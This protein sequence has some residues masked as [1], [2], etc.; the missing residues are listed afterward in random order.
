[1]TT[2]TSFFTNES[3]L[4]LKDRFNT[5]VKGTALF[6]CLVGYFYSSGFYLIYPALEH[7]DNIRILI[8]ISTS[9][10]TFRIIEEGNKVG[11]TDIKFSHSETKQTIEDAVKLEMETSDD[12]HH[13]EEGVHKFIEW[14]RSGKLIIKAYPSQKIHAKLYI[15]TFKDGS[16]DK[17][18]VITGSS[19]FT[20][21]GLEDN[22]EFNVELK[23]PGDYEFAKEKFDELWEDAVDVSE[24]YVETIEDKS[25]FS[26]KVTPYNLYLK[27]LY[28]YFKTDLNETG[29][30]NLDH[31]PEEFM[32]LEY[33]EQAVLNAKKILLEYGGVFISDVVGLGKTIITAMLINQLPG[34][35]TLVIAPPALLDKKNAGSWVNTFFLFHISAQ[36]E[37]LGKL[38]NLL[39]AASDRFDT[40]VI[41]EA[42]RFRNETTETYEKLSEIC[43]GKKVVLVTATPYN[44]SPKDILSLI[45]LFQKPKKSTIPNLPDLESFFNGLEKN[46]KKLNRKNN[47]EEYISLTQ[48]N[49]KEIREKV[50]KYL[51][52]RRTRTEIKK[53][54]GKDLKRQGLSFPEVAKPKPLFYLLDDKEDEIFNRT[55]ELIASEFNYARYMPMKYYTGKIDKSVI[56]GQLNMGRFMKIL[57]VKRLESSFFAFRQSIDRFLKTYNI[58]LDA[59]NKGNVH[60]SKSYITRVF[61]FLEINDDESIQRLID[62]GKVDTFN[63]QDFTKEF[64]EHLEKDRNMLIQI[65]ELWKDIDRDPKLLTFIEELKS[66][67]V[68]KKNH[69]IIFTESKETAGYLFENID[70]QFA[71]EVLRFDGSS[72]AAERDKVI[73]NFDAKS[74]NPDSK[75]RILITTEVLSEGVNLHRSNVVINYDIPWNP[76]RLMQRIGR[77]NRVDTKF[78]TIHTYNFFPSV[79]GDSHI[80]LKSA[81]EIKIASFLSLLGDDAELLTDGEPID[82]HALFETLNSTEIIE[83][84]DEP[85]SELKYLE[86]IKE[87]REN[88]SELFNK[89]KKIPRKSRT[90]KKNRNHKHSLITYFRLGQLQKF[91]IAEGLQDSRELDFMQSAELFECTPETKKQK[92]PGD[93]FDLLEL[94]KRSFAEI[95]VDDVNEIKGKGGRDSVTQILKVLKI[96]RRSSQQLT[97][98]QELY[99]EKVI[100]QLN[101]GGIPKKTLKSILKSLKNLSDEV[102]NPIKVVGVLQNI[103]SN[104]LL[105]SHYVEENHLTPGKREVVL[106]LYLTDD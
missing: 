73:S 50:L 29:E 78:T 96:T 58:F 30:L 55:I 82:S 20:K 67:P 3:G 86:V 21:S 25:W 26:D 89:I 94:N 95:I 45:K 92:I 56:Q 42:H 22:L 97:N 69:I 64:I 11:Q 35:R 6:D 13:V 39:G 74:S 32:K 59:F 52:V 84:E 33:Q 12:T 47:F 14:I 75:Y 81:A 66:D 31:T 87:V 5:L 51:M 68:L 23:N 15:M 57:L 71:G 103:I 41:D 49:A 85:D 27:F 80:A 37:S 48:R 101:E 19:N 100:M 88:D 8:G 43:R 79:Q 65:Q 76:T 104:R 72:H 9:G 17:G 34:S 16:I 106:S 36:F 105:D 91:F 28:E 1:M 40:V 4:R 38:D 44:N 46:I 18:R 54:F 60:I 61:D 70:K 102:M 7:T 99:L 2:D 93:M 83:G 63:S 77:I 53:Y 24:K 90:A 98:D 62:E 10:D